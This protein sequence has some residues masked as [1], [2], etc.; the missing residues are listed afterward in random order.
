MRMPHTWFGRAPG[1]LRGRPP[2]WSSGCEQLPKLWCCGQQQ[3]WS[4]PWGTRLPRAGHGQLH[5]LT[6]CG[7]H[8]RARAH[9]RRVVA[10]G[11]FRAR[12]DVARIEIAME[13]A[14]RERLVAA[15]KAIMEQL[16]AQLDLKTRMLVGQFY[17]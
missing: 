5:P 16:T 4:K 14:V 2:S 7:T 3:D 15:R 12:R 11:S 6:C 10:E 9:T 13:G 8:A 17:L 1:A